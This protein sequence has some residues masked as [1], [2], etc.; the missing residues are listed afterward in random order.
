MKMSMQKKVNKPMKNSVMVKILTICFLIFQTAVRAQYTQTIKGTVVDSYSKEPIAGAA[1]VLLETNPLMGSTS[2][3]N[4]IYK[5]AGVPVGRYDMRIAMLGYEPVII[6]EVMVNSGKEVVLNAE[7]KESFT[8]L[9]EV[10]VKVK[11]KNKPQN[12]MS[13]TSARIFSVE[14][15]RRYAGG[16]DDPV[17]LVSAFAGVSGGSVENNGIVIRG[18]SPKGVLWRLE[19]VEIPNPNHFGDGEIIGGGFICALSSQ[20]LG[21]SDFLT[22]SFAAEYG[23]ALSGVFDMK[24]RE[25]NNE[26]RE[27]A[28]QVGVLGIDLAAEGPFMNGKNSSYLFNYRYSTFALAKYMLP[29]LRDLPEYQDL[30]FKMNFP[31]D[32]AG[33]FSL[34]GFGG[35][36]NISMGAIS[37]STKWQWSQSRTEFSHR[38]NF[39]AI[40]LS[41]KYILG[42]NSFINTTLEA[43]DISSFENKKEL[44]YTMEM[45]TVAKTGSSR[46]QYS[47]SSYINHKFG[48]RHLNRT[49]VIISNLQYDLDI[50]HSKDHEKTL[51]NLA[52]EKGNSYLIQAYSQS[53]FDI[54]SKISSTCGIHYQYFGL[55]RR[56]TIEPRIALSWKILSKSTLTFGYGKHSQTEILRYYFIRQTNAIDTIYPNKHLDFAKAHHFVLGYDMNITDNLRL[57]IEPYFQYLYNIPVIADSS[58][59]MINVTEDTDFNEPLVNKGTGKNYGID[60]TL[61]RFLSKGYYYLLTMSV[62]QSKYTAGDHVERNTRYNRNYI[63]N[64]LGGKEWQIGKRSKSNFLGIN[65]RLY[66]MGGERFIPLKV[67]ETISE[68]T[69]VYDYYHSFSQQYDPS[70]RFDF[71]I[72][73]RRNHKKYSS[74]LALQYLNVFGSPDRNGYE[75]N[76]VSNSIQERKEIYQVPV[77]SYKIEF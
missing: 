1:V 45:Y 40:G 46:Q 69:N 18:N 4:G 30:T 77:L 39:G 49:G 61:E 53:K 3:I 70:Y 7:I 55:N 20:V 33:T 62:F 71:T 14:E 11:T 17:R 75:Y 42:K 2:D 5:I 25:G 59:S 74:T 47:L 73:Y 29:S 43:S 31:T 24:L 26:K 51:I 54:N 8:D 10:V 68:K 67:E 12:Q 57:K 35:I 19:G 28:I 36:D 72:T 23:N 66:L 48:S 16:I 56:Y 52:D 21:N 27:Y 34:W 41:H 37:D 44:D 6:P 64:I 15:A 76:F 65:L 60:L 63:C 32:K 13:M 50:N 58:F 22:G 38:F 9:K